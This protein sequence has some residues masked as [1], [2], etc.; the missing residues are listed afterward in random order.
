MSAHTE[1][2][3]PQQTLLPTS[4]EELRNIV[5]SEANYDRWSN[6][7]FPH[8]KAKGL[9]DKRSKEVTFTTK[10]GD[11]I[12][13]LIEIRP[14]VGGRCF[15]TTTYDVLLALMKLWRNRK[16]P[17]EPIKVTLREIARE[18]DLKVNGRVTAMIA[19][20]L[21]RLSRNTITWQFVFRT[22][23]NETTTLEDQRIL[24][25]FRYTEKKARLAG[26]D[27]EPFVLVR[28]SEHIR[29]NC[30][31]NVT[32]PVNLSARKSIRSSVAK[33]V[34]SRIDNILI[35]QR[36]QENT[37][38][39]IVEHFELNK[40]RYKH[41]SRRRELCEQIAKSLNG[42]ETSRPGIFLQVT[43]AETSNKDDWK[44]IFTTNSDEDLPETATPVLR[45]EVVNNEADQQ[46]LIE[47]M[48]R[49]VGAVRENER[50][51]QRF[52]M[53]YSMDHIH[54]ALGEYRELIERNPNIS[55][56]PA[57]FTSL[58]HSVAHRLGLEWI[59]PCDANCKYRPENQL[60]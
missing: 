15:T 24:D 42:V 17:D 5:A 36:T 13:G 40:S 58:M 31:E 26:M 25:T 38:S 20:E 23:D 28:F 27:Y 48:G 37:A 30:R 11:M 56:K 2:V 3:T 21:R 10:Q 35:K 55:N 49:V 4:K 9:D 52:A 8:T 6:F 12:T 41:K 59:K 44:C 18:L 50:L 22:Y 34:Y 45:L 29:K 33:C 43:V 7:L 57:Y 60:M 16:M 46:F 53:H 19:D 14:D 47:E 32:I 1:L 39:Y 54:R 51:Y